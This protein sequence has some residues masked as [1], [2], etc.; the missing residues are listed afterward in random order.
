MTKMQ[1]TQQIYRG[2]FPDQHPTAEQLLLLRRFG[3]REDVI[4]RLT[5]AE[6]FELIRKRLIQAEEQ[7]EKLARY[8][9]KKKW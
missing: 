8:M 5:R 7:A 4:A 2:K 9:H 3:I 1:Q 6:A